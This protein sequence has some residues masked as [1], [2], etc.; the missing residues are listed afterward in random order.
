MKLTKQTIKKA[1]DIEN[2]KNSTCPICSSYTDK[3]NEIKLLNLVSSDTYKCIGCGLHFRDPLPSA[4]LME[5]YYSARYFRYSNKLEK[6]IAENQSNWIRCL[7]ESNNVDPQKIYYLEFGAGRGWLVSMMNRFVRRSIG[8]EADEF[9]TSWGKDNLQ[10]DMRVG[11]ITATSISN[12]DL[13]CIP[14]FS[15][16]HVLEHLHEPK[17]I[18]QALSVRCKDAYLFLEVPNGKFEGKVMA[19]DRSPHSSM[20]QHFWSFTDKS[21]ATLLE[22]SG[23]D[24]VQIS[25]SGSHYYYDTKLQRLSGELYLLNKISSLI[26]DQPRGRKWLLEV[27]KMCSRIIAVLLVT[28]KS[29][30]FH[31]HL[32]SRKNMPVIRILA[33]KKVL[34]DSHLA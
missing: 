14:L 18:L 11:F 7:L 29:R 25:E 22:L 31:N 30:I 6:Q 21:L 3:M 32:R 24:I 5:D 2:N 33:K 27:S 34:C 16:S 20:G 4:S 19:L 28:L 12:I 13:H 9:S 10:A 8:F 26:E 23:W 17:D 1:E 15:L